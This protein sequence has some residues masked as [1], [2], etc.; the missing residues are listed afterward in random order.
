M[1]WNKCS[2]FEYDKKQSL[3]GAMVQILRVRMFNIK[4]YVYEW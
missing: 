1:D 4:G 3:T 2:A